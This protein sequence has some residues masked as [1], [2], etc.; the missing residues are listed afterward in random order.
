MGC[1][2]DQARTSAVKGPW[3]QYTGE[4]SITV[5][6]GSTGKRYRFERKGSRQRI[7]RR[8]LANVA[9]IPN[10]IPG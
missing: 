9:K 4:K 8:D 3:Y 5:V 1:C 7:D 2:G 6:G 10:L